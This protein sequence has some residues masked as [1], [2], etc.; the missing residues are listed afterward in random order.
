MKKSG[1]LIL[2]ATLSLVLGIVLFVVGMGL[3]D[4]DFDK[5]DTTEY[6]AKSYAAAKDERIDRIYVDLQTFP[7]VIN[8][9][10]N[11][12]LDYYEATDAAVSV[13]LENGIL[14]IAEKYRY[15]PFKTGLFNLM[16]NKYKFVLT[17]PNGADLLL[18]GPNCDLKANGIVFSKL[19]FDVVNLDVSLT[20][21]K[22]DVLT[23]DS[24]NSD[25]VLTNC[26]IGRVVVD[27]VNSDVVISGGAY[28]DIKVDATNNDVSI[29]RVVVKS[30][31]LSGLNGDYLLESVT[32]DKLSA[33]ALNLD[34]NIEIVGVRSE[35]TIKTD[36]RGLPREQTGTTDKRIYLE[37]QNCDVTLDFVS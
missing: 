13:K 17:V 26:E 27:S 32:L 22:A 23:I 33:D 8:A 3:I 1:K 16:R 18:S 15:N 36:G 34:A 21:C 37:G 11:I 7:I 6:T 25:V 14:R 9:G 31:D 2:S 24:T 19:D 35:F 28:S 29:N 10:D 4:W 20:S 30:V 5:L 12:S